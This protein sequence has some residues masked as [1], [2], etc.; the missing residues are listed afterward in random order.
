MLCSAA[1]A[2]CVFVVTKGVAGPGLGIRRRLV[3]LFGG[4]P[5]GSR[6]RQG[7]LEARVSAGLTWFHLEP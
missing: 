7:L 3:Q 2:A 5:Q 4:T 6:I 1:V